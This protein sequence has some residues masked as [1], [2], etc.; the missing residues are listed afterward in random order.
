MPNQVYIGNMTPEELGQHEQPWYNKPL[1]NA[2]RHGKYGEIMPEDEFIGLIKIVDAFDLVKLTTE[3]T[4][5]VKEKL[6]AHPLMREDLIARLKL[7]MI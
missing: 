4:A 3:F 2:D 5:E 6:E 1:E 7:A